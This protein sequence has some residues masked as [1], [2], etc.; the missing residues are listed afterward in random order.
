MRLHAFIAIVQQRAA[1]CLYRMTSGIVV[2]L[3]AM[4]GRMSL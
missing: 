2:C 4:L 3:Q 1:A